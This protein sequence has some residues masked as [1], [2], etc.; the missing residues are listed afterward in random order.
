[1]VANKDQ[2]SGTIEISKDGLIKLSFESE[3]KTLKSTYFMV[4]NQE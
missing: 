2:E 4:R 3:D 1:L